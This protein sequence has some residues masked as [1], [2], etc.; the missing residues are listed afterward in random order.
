[1]TYEQSF[2]ELLETC[3]RIERYRFILPI[4]SAREYL[5]NMKWLKRRFSEC[6]SNQYDVSE[7]FVRA[8]LV[9]G[10]SLYV[11][12]REYE[13]LVNERNRAIRELALIEVARGFMPPQTLYASA[14]DHGTVADQDEICS[15]WEHFS[16][17]QAAFFTAL[18][19]VEELARYDAQ[20]MSRVRV[21]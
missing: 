6:W 1:M 17:P 8:S 7:Y 16:I 9:E 5:Q 18:I 11:T 14:Y 19:P 10:E 3:T 2:Y 13:R 21:R 15:F 20:L 4:Q 12:T